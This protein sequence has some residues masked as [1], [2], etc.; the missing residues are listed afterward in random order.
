[1]GGKIHSFYKDF[2]IIIMIILK[3]KSASI[4]RTMA[5]NDPKFKRSGRQ[6]K[7]EGSHN[8]T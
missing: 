6:L 3:M 2:L 7:A 1:M 4:L 5:K 8:F